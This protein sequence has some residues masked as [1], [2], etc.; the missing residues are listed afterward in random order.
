MREVQLRLWLRRHLWEA[1]LTGHTLMLAVTAKPPRARLPALD[2]TPRRG[3]RDDIW[4]LEDWQR[5]PGAKVRLPPPLLVLVF[6]VLWRAELH[7]MREGRLMCMC[8]AA[9]G[10][11]SELAREK[12]WSRIHLIPLLTAEEDRDLVRRH[13]ADQKREKELLG[14]ETSPYNSDRYVFLFRC[15]PPSLPSFI[16]ALGMS[17]RAT[18]EGYADLMG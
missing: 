15:S 8:M 14:S 7:M 18:V 2:P 11:D 4:I 3:W 17:S 6:G 5:D 16:M 12:M 9:N 10:R 13:L 1:S